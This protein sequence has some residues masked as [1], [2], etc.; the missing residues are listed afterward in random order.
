MDSADYL[1]FSKDEELLIEMFYENGWCFGSR[2]ADPSDAGFIPT[3]HIFVQKQ[4]EEEQLA[5][6]VI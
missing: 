3:N 5:P 6:P 2:L 1:Q 4:E